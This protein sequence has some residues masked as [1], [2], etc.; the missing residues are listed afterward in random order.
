MQVLSVCPTVTHE[1]LRARWLLLL[2]SHSSEHICFPSEGSY[3][4]I[5]VLDSSLKF[6]C[7]KS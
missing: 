1:E 2:N 6:I 4:V 3:N 7:E 5:I